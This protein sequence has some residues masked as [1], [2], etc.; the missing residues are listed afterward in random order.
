M[1]ARARVEPG[2]V[3]VAV[4]ALVWTFVMYLAVWRRH[5][6]YGTF[7]LDIG[8]H[9]QLVWQL[10]RGR[11]F[12]T[13][14]GLPAFGHNATFGYFLLI[15]LS[16]LRIDGPQT[17]NLIQT[18]VV[19]SAT[20][21]VYV[22]ARRRLGAAWPTAAVALAWLLHP[23]VQNMVWETF[24]P[25]VIAATFL[26]WAY[27]FADA[28]RWRSFAAMVLLAIIWKS[29]VALFVVMLGIWVALRRDRRV[30]IR[31]SV[32][33][34][35]WFLVVVNLLIPRLAGGETVFGSLYGDLG[36]TPVEV[37]VN[38]VRHPDLLADRVG[39]AHVVRYGRDLAAPY[40]F[41]PLLAP[42]Q[43]ALG[44]PQYAVNV[45]SEDTSPREWDWAPHYQAMPMVALTLALVEALGWLRR[46]RGAL[47]APACA[48]VVAF[49]LATSAAWGS[50]P[51]GVRW[52]YFW[53]ED[54]DPLRGAKDAALSSVSND[55]GVSTHYLFT[56]HVAKREV[57]Y[58]FPNP[59]RKQ[60]YGVDTTERGDPVAV[61]WIVLDEGVMSDAEREVKSC[62]LD[63]A[64]FEEVFRDREISVLRRITG[65]EPVDVACR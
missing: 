1:L 64:T 31:T 56:A 8:F 2:I 62:I 44:L 49:G 21:P 6:R 23:A 4:G 20:I 39:D 29:D 7:D 25:E 47:V 28:E 16:W 61:E 27:V 52:S 40:A 37:A 9:T 55:H 57:A 10:A 35:V 48:L 11:S 58:T 19:A 14:L 18:V 63:A 17:L 60:F 34:A 43:L 15:P 42:V 3:V 46:R 50:L 51:F 36:D 38:S 41:V 45:L 65:V 13:I 30:G 26:L 12:S 5:D 53:S 33:G 24:H 32:F 54:D 22:L 59:W